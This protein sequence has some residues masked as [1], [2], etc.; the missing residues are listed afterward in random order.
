ME[1]WKN[2]YWG[3]PILSS[4][5]HGS[6]RPISVISF[7]L[8]YWFS[9]YNPW[10]YHLVNVIL[11][12]VATGLVLKLG[13]CLLCQKAARLSALLFAVHPIHTEAVASIVG[14][15]ELIACVFYLASLLCYIKYCDHHHTIS[16][17]ESKPAF[18]KAHIRN[19]R[20]YSPK[21]RGG[22]N[23]NT[24]QH[25]RPAEKKST[26]SS[27]NLLGFTVLFAC[28]STISKET[29]FSAL[30]VCIFYELLLYKCR[31]NGTNSV[32]L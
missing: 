8:N 3:T 24:N 15:A 25:S 11:H 17:C 19:R 2:D 28:L 32:S 1:L 21:N 31:K 22:R 20:N 27:Y 23:R 29:G 5:S 26:A 18:L 13:D 4:G 16:V 14:R 6:Y 30:P 12:V 9:G 10:S 7:R